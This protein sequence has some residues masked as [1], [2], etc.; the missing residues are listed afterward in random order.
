MSESVAVSDQ[1]YVIDRETNDDGTVNAE[2]NRVDLPDEPGGSFEVE[3]LLPDGQTE[4]RK[5]RWA[6]RATEDFEIVRLCRHLGFTLSQVKELEGSMVKWDGGV[7]YPEP[8]EPIWKRSA[9]KSPFDCSLGHAF[10]LIPVW[11][12][13]SPLG[14]FD[15]DAQV[16]WG[17]FLVLYSAVWTATIAIFLGVVL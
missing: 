4:S 1:L 6:K 11:L 17:A 3:F 5:Y 14:I 10:L 15:D 2:V 7:V 8:K 9:P 13:F 16:R 12:T